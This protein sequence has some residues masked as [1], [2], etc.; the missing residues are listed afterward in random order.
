MSCTDE[1]EVG[2]S[3][4]AELNE[5][6]GKLGLAEE[7]I[8]QR[9]ATVDDVEAQLALLEEAKAYRLRRLTQQEEFAKRRIVTI[10][11]EMAEMQQR[12]ANMEEKLEEYSGE[13]GAAQERIE[14]LMRKLDA[15]A[16]LGVDAADGAEKVAL[17]ERLL[18]V[19][20]DLEKE[21]E[22]L[23]A[24]LREKL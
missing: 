5:R 17:I 14:E 1:S 3:R 23:R 15:V 11:A 22:E 20:D 21:N 18:R 16:G 12:I 7:E 9:A 19:I 8:E 10:E 24:A 4:I 13:D 2:E 6:I